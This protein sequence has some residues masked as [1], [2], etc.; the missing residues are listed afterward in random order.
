MLVRVKSLKFR[1]GIWFPVSTGFFL[2]SSCL[3]MPRL[4]RCIAANAHPERQNLFG[5]VQ[6]GLDT[7]PGGL[8]EVRDT[9]TAGC[10]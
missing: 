5:I 2:V 9:L 10:I 3:R 7:S 8:R 4:D 6:G 1:H